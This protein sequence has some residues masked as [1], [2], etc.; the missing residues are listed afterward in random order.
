MLA[1]PFDRV[2]AKARETGDTNLF[3]NF[4][5]PRQPFA[6]L[7]TKPISEMRRPRHQEARAEKG[8][9]VAN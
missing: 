3:L 5:F 8:S 4:R 6:R 1:P 9:I 2:G 7:S